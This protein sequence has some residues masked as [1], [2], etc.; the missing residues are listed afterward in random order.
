MVPMGHMANRVAPELSEY[1]VAVSS[2][3]AEDRRGRQL[4]SRTEGSA[5]RL[6]HRSLTSEGSLSFGNRQGACSCMTT[7]SSPSVGE[8]GEHTTLPQAAGSSSDIEPLSVEGTQLSGMISSL[9]G[10]HLDRSPMTS[11]AVHPR[12]LVMGVYACDVALAGRRITTPPGG[13]QQRG[14]PRRI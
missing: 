5:S 8:S 2:G 14:A 1:T 3:A 12:R 11:D 7:T 10:C 6:L 13:Q 9:A 4:P